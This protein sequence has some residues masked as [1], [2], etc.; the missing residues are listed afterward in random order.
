[1]EKG[2]GSYSKRSMF[3][4]RVRAHILMFIM[5]LLQNSPEN[6]GV[7][8]LCDIRSLYNCACSIVIR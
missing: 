3:R 6:K 5:H 1:M 7:I 8:T 2:T 4:Y